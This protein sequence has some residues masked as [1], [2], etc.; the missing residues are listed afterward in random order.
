MPQMCQQSFSTLLLASLM[1][2]FLPLSVNLECSLPPLCLAKPLGSK[3]ADDRAH[4]NLFSPNYWKVLR[5]APHTPNPITL[6]LINVEV[7]LKICSW[8]GA[9]ASCINVIYLLG[10]LIMPRHF[11]KLVLPAGHG[12]EWLMAACPPSVMVRTYIRVRHEGSHARSG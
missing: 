3:E 10:K 8:A 1:I 9:H 7:Y 2:L 11:D 12:L 4:K 5:K 6:P